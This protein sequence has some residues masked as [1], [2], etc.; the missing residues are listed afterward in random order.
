[1]KAIQRDAL[2]VLR[3]DIQQFLDVGLAPQ[4][5]DVTRWVRVL[6]Q[7]L[8]DAQPSK[9]RDLGVVA[10]QELRS[11]WQATQAQAG[12]RVIARRVYLNPSDFERITG[13]PAGTPRSGLGMGWHADANVQ[14]GEARFE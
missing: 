13:T 8:G 9:Q 3:D 10:I 5:R 4:R 12:R 7:V 1:M 6:E 11:I 2:V 14:P